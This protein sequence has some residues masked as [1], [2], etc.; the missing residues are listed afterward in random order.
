M[1][2]FE[3]ITAGKIY[4]VKASLISEPHNINDLLMF[5]CE[6][7]DTDIIN[8]LIKDFKADINFVNDLGYTPL[9]W[10]CTCG[11]AKSVSTLIDAGADIN[12]PSPDGLTPL[13]LAVNLNR[14]AITQILLDAGVKVTTYDA[15][16]KTALDIAKEKHFDTI[17]DLLEIEPAEYLLPE[18]IL[19]SLTG[20]IL[21]LYD[22]I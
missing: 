14:I 22:Y 5:S 6:I 4:D 7:G 15:N 20:Y 16:G 18:N 2:I 11:K 12:Q 17:V 13:L 19:K 21:D 9:I 3:A 10:A 8:M 1:D